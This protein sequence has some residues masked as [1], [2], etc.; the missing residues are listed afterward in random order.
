MKT[1]LLL[2]VIFIVI[3]ILAFAYQGMSYTTREKI[4][5]L[6]PLYMTADQ[7]KALQLPPVV[8]GAALTCG[9]V[10]LTMGSK[11]E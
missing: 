9:I 6:G 10:L 5:D 1:H 7:T 2:G 3:A 4:V 11:K 8:G